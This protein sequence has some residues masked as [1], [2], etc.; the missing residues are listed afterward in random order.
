MSRDRYALCVVRPPGYPHVAAFDE[1]AA[2]ICLGLRDLGLAADVHANHIDPDART[3]LLGCHLLE[4][5]MMARFRP[6]TIVLNT[7]QVAETASGWQDRL[8]A[9]VGRFECWDY[10]AGNIPLLRERTA[11]PV[12]LLPIG[13]HPGLRRIA[14]AARQDID[15]L[16]YGSPSARRDEVLDAIEAAGARVER[17]FGVYG[18]ERDAVIARSRIVLNV[19]RADVHLFEVVRVF[20]LLINGCAVVAEVN[21]TTVIEPAYRNAVCAVPFDGIVQACLGLLADEAARAALRVR[22][23]AAMEALPQSRLI[24]PLLTH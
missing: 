17:M 23:T 8:F 5:G 21:D 11:M 13:G 3:I 7:E 6:D 15:V 1:L 16:F 24:A 18:A 12:R 20:Y 19:H 14:P 4:E 2:L 22:A 10:S 9:W